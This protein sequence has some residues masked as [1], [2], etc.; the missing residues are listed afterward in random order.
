MKETELAQVIVEWLNNK[1]YEVFQEVQIDNRVADI[2]AKKNDQL[3]IIECK[4]SLNLLLLEQ[5]HN[6]ITYSD[7]VSVAVPVSKTYTRSN[8][9]AKRI[10]REFKIGCLE[11]KKDKYNKKYI[12][13]ETID[14]IIHSDPIR[15]QYIK[16][17]EEQKWYQEAGSS[18][19]GHFTDFKGTID[20]LYNLAK[21]NPGIE[22]KQALKEIN[23]HYKNDN[24][25]F[26]CIKKYIDQN[27]IKKI[28]LIDNNIYI[29]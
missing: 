12:I 28:K 8:T 24:N 14:P 23:H 6:W 10:L 15:K 4:T 7:Y 20:K 25:A 16:L 1:Q 9:F 2:V 27:I 21:D 19:G 11:L 22:L 29:N 13:R 26:F 3:W 5:V 18:N 17:H